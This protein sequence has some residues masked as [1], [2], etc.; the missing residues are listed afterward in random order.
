MK[1][2][3]ISMM[4]MSSIDSKVAELID[5]STVSTQHTLASACLHGWSA[6]IWPAVI[7][8]ETD[9]SYWQKQGIQLPHKKRLLNKRGMLGCFFS[10]YSL[11]Q[12]C[13]DTDQTIIVLEHDAEIIAQQ[14]SWSCDRGIIKLNRSQ[15]SQLP[16]SYLSGIY[17]RWASGLYGY[18]ISPKWARML[19]SASHRL[20]IVAADKFMGQDLVPWHY[21]T[22][23][24]V[25]HR[26][27]YRS[28][29]SRFSSTQI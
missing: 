18:V 16:E 24:A 9:L 11:W 2:Y 1:S 26:Y 20:P 15:Q 28:D 5:Y 4:G 17:G 7:G 10:H 6:S 27:Y 22:E 29:G 3:I 8:A 14:Q 12:H 21:A 19:I 23:V 13:V 25:S